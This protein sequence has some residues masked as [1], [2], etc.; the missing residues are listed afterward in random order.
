MRTIISLSICCVFSL[1]LTLAA[2][3]EQS[4]TVTAEEFF[5]P[6]NDNGKALPADELYP[7][8]RLLAFTFFSPELADLPRMRAD[9]FTAAGPFY[10]VGADDNEHPID[11]IHVSGLECLYKVG[12]HIDFVHNPN[13]VMPSISE[14]KE[15][16]TSQVASVAKNKKI[17]WWYLIPEELRYWRPDEMQ[18]IKAATEAIRAADPCDRP[19]WMYEPNHRNAA[20]L[21]K[22]LK[23]QDICGKGM[24]CNYSGNQKSRIWCRWTL[25]QEIAAIKTVNSKAIPIVVLEMIEDPEV[26]YATMIPAWARHDA[27]LALVSGA[28]GL[29]IYCGIRRDK[30]SM[31]DKYYK[32]YASVAND[33]RGQ[34]GLS[35]VFLFGQK[36]NNIKID[37]TSGPAVLKLDYDKKVHTYPSISHLDTA[38]KK[39]RYL[40]MVNSANSAVSAVVSGLPTSKIFRQDVF[41]DSAFVETRDGTFK[42][43]LPAL[44]VKCFRFKP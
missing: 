34:L 5:R 23:Y 36:R 37:V 32:G 19:I 39:N 30:I 43:D 14:I 31:F 1:T 21:A 42:V 15:K 16:I 11:K 18:Y 9:G 38:Y 33:L 13:Y 12:L 2:Q 4:H 7:K 25:E 8:G 27:Y 10:E 28:K 17:A 40:F 20:A 41:K 44:G 35:Q 26:S 29:A 22:T 3:V 24:Y 6:A